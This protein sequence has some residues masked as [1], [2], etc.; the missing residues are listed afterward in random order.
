MVGNI[1]ASDVIAFNSSTGITFVE[2]TGVGVNI[3]TVFSFALDEYGFLIAA[4]HSRHVGS[5]ISL[6]PP[7]PSQYHGSCRIL[8]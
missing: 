3:L 2:P 5:D 7:H 8:E 4:V 1:G 6:L